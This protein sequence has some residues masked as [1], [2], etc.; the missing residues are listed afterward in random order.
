M[1]HLLVH[2]AAER[3]CAGLN[4]KEIVFFED[5]PYSLEQP[6]RQKALAQC[7]LSTEQHLFVSLT[8]PDMRAKETAIRLYTSQSKDIA[9]DLG[10]S[11]DEILEYAYYDAD[12]E[13]TSIRER[14]WAPRMETL[15]VLRCALN[16][17]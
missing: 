16:I 2:E 12:H 9:G 3:A 10:I 14:F 15:D 6:A 5:L 13:A 7:N 1:D 4:R 17:Y 11:V 8:D